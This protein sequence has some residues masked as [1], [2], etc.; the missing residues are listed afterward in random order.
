MAHILQLKL[1][2]GEW[3]IGEAQE[4]L[5]HKDSITLKKP[6]NIRIAKGEG[7]DQ[8]RIMLVPFDPTNPEGTIEIYLSS[9]QARPLEV[10]KDLHD[11]YVHQTSSIEIVSDLQAVK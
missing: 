11:A 1:T 10:A 6:L 9:I 5:Q 7:P 3:V 2:S 8:Y 4:H